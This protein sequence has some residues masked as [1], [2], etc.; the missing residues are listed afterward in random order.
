MPKTSYFQ[1]IVLWFNIVKYCNYLDYIV[2]YGSIARQ[3]L[4]KHIPAE[5]YV[6]N[7]RTS[8]AR[9]QVS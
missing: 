6:R 4:G 7:S 8:I 1:C 2:T 3:R 5:A 9:Q